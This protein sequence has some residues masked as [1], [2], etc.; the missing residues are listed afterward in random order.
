MA[1]KACSVKGGPLTSQ[2]PVQDRLANNSEP[3]RRTLLRAFSAASLNNVAIE[4]LLP[5]PG[6][7]FAVR[8]AS[9]SHDPF[10]LRRSSAGR[11]LSRFRYHN[12]EGFFRSLEDA[13]C[14][15]MRQLLYLA[16]I[17][18]QLALS[19]HLLDVG[20]EDN[21]CARNIGL[22]VSKSLAYANAT[23]LD[24][25]CPKMAKLADVLTPYS[26]WNAPSTPG[27]PSATD[28]GFS[29]QDIST[30]LRAL[31]DHVHRVAGHPRP[32][33]WREWHIAR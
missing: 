22:H 13:P 3:S 23:G 5:S 33:G 18:A 25:D 20:F 26:T 9:S 24:H 12:A 28:G 2:R 32:R 10:I 6:A 21:W 14:D 31:L 17:V 7:A 11:A 4:R 19:S 1:F 16:G 15:T 30:L 8:Q 27:G 29:P